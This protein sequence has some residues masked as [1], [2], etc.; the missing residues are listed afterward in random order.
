MTNIRDI[1]KNMLAGLGG[2]Y[3]GVEQTN[4]EIHEEIIDVAVDELLDP[5]GSP[6]VYADI[7][8]S[9]GGFGDLS[10]CYS[11]VVHPL[12]CELF[13]S[14]VDAEP[15]VVESNIN[16]MLNF[17]HEDELTQGILESLENKIWMAMNSSNRH[18]KAN[19]GDIRRLCL[20]IL[21]NVIGRVTQAAH[22]YASRIARRENRDLP[23]IQI[24][25]RCST[26]LIPANN[27]VVLRIVVAYGWVYV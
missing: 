7:V 25:N 5:F 19:S 24:E 3:D 21:E 1:A 26:T 20:V 17:R 8:R 4:I 23:F 13:N 16:K 14:A 11:R 27:P 10:Y 12:L 18:V 15:K 6:F 9:D 22:D 2:D